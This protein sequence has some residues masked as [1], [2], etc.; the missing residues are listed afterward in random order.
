MVRPSLLLVVGM[1]RSGT[2][3]LGGI[4]QRLGVSLPG[5]TIARDQHNPEGYFEWDAVVAIQERLLIDLERW[6]PAAEGTQ[7]LPE[8]WLHHPATVEARQQLREL[9]ATEAARQ[10]SLWAIKDPRCSRLLPLWIELAQE[11][12]IPL[13]LLLAVRDPAEVTAS[14]LHRDGPLTGMDA[15]RAQQLWWRHNLEVV[16]GARGAGL[17]LGVIDFSGWFQHP[18]KQLQRL[19]DACPGLNPSPAQCAEAL[20]LIEPGHRR[21]LSQADAS[22]L[23]PASRR[24][25]QRLLRCPLPRRMPPVR[26][27]MPPQDASA[28]APEDW[29]VWLQRHRHFPA[30]RAHAV[31]P[32]A[33]D[34]VL[35]VCG[36]AW[37]ELEP[38]QWLQRAPLQDLGGRRIDPERCGP[39]RISLCPDPAAKGPLERIA[40]NL[41]LPP[42]ER[43][44]HWLEHLRAQQLIFDPEPAR[45]LLLRTLGLPAWWLDPHAPTNGW[46]QQPL[47]SMASA[48][49][50]QLGM[51]P[52][53]PGALVVLG[54]AGREFEQALTQES[55]TGTVLLP[56]IQYWP[57]WPE[58]VVSDAVAGLARA[59]WLDA[60]S[61]EAAQML[62]A[63]DLP[64]SVTPADLRAIQAGQPLRVLAEDRPSPATQELFAWGHGTSPTAAVVVSLFNYADRINEALDSVAA[65]TAEGL[66]LIVVDD[67]SSD[68]GAERVKGWM[69]RCVAHVDHPFVR[70]LL[71]SHTGN[72]GLAAARNTA[73]AAAQSPWCFVLDADNALYPRAVETCLQL[74]GTGDGQLAVVH[75]LLAVEVEAGRPD[76]Q[77]SLVS[78]ASWQRSRLLG[79]NV[80]DAMALVRRSAWQA[81][82]GYTHIEGGWEDYDFWCKLLD[83][84][85]YGLQ[86]PEVLAVYRS[87]ADSMSHTA[88]N[89]SWRALSR[90][91]QDRHPWLDLPLATP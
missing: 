27:P 44:Q 63:G 90:T 68:A 64:A 11:L 17:P 1:H 89:R 76:D 32:L 45:V 10:S 38:H 83:A 81:V 14:L 78:T 22:G 28:C 91:L 77:R 87:H 12:A 86:C 5:D 58:L 39:H 71:L 85:F 36:P 29:A 24:L 55:R 30:P 18:E 31:P 62:Q 82:G 49:A 25:H 8:D 51:A 42:P 88:T 79:G 7:A 23:H 60:A 53:E 66:E 84:G 75:P 70:L 57:G 6:W 67:A 26:P 21:S 2:S 72:A 3:L 37:Q 33:A 40:L 61:Q 74:A 46:L 4:L 13:Q 15:N 80:V 19:I 43:A 20:A 16:H 41:E 35:H 47:A 56:R 69:E 65:Q 59:G 34:P 73:F 50:Q 48:W 52:P 9:L 54:A